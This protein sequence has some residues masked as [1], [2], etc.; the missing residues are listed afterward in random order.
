[1]MTDETEPSSDETTEPPATIHDD[2]RREEQGAPRTSFYD[3]EYCRGTRVQL[4]QSDR[5]PT[6]ADF[7]PAPQ[8]PPE[9]NMDFFRKRI[10][11]AMRQRDHV[12]VF[13]Q[14]HIPTRQHN[15]R[16]HDTLTNLMT[17]RNDIEKELM[18]MLSDIAV[19]G[20]PLDPQRDIEDAYHA[21]SA[22]HNQRNRDI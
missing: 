7:S 12:P 14:M 21:A 19:D 18:D 9:D 15:A 22:R 13:L 8:P 6:A 1:M 4:L 11:K 5:Q 16:L 17:Q 10:A 3:E 20:T 2:A